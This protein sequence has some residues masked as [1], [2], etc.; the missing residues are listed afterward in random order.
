[1]TDEM[2]EAIDEWRKSQPDFPSRLEAIRRLLEKGL[3]TAAKSPSSTKPKSGS[4]WGA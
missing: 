1:M 2:S 3:G 4:P